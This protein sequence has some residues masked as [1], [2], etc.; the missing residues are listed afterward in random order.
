MLF[1]TISASVYGIDA[2]LVEVEVD[3]GSARMQD[4]NVVGL[5]DNAVKES[6][7]RIKSA[8]RNCGFEFP[9]GQGVTI[10]LA[11]ADV[12]K[13]G[14]GFDLPMAPGLAGCMGQFFGKPLDQCMFL[15]E[16]SLDG[17]V[18]PVRGA[19]SAALAARDKGLK[20]IAVP[21][22]KCPRSRRGRRRQC[23][24]AEV[25]SASRRLGQFAG[26]LHSSK[27]RC[28]PNAIGG[29]AVQRRFARRSWAAIRQARAGSFLCWWPQHFVYRATRRRQNHAGQAHP[30]NTAAHVPGRSHRNHAHP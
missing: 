27:G 14:S 24:R 26:I 6:R 16:L 25:P 4:F 3:V 9:Y 19:L 20:A 18:R 13:E 2:Y 29:R 10:N 17:G 5:P 23:V 15:G 22:G 30:H 21:E 1:K 28:G 8:L 7:E 11:P 12:R